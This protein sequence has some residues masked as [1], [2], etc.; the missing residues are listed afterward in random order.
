MAQRKVLSVA[1]ASQRVGHVYLHNEQLKGWAKSTSAY[2][3]T[4]NAR[5]K[6][7]NWIAFYQPDL[8]ILE[9]T[10]HHSRKGDTSRTLIDALSDEVHEQGVQL[11][12]IP[13]L[14]Q[15]P[16]KYDEAAALAQQFPELTHYVPDKPPIWESEPPQTIIF[17]ALHLALIALNPD[18]A[19]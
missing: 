1:V 13:R 19:V 14:R 8:V 17:E 4:A 16:N 11:R 3:S 15:H 7:Q 18:T 10:D 2:K 5:S 9:L 6:I 12:Q